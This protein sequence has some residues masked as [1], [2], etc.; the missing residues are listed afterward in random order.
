MRGMTGF[1][2]IQHPRSLDGQFT[3]R[4]HTP[5][6]L[7][8]PQ[9]TEMP[10][11]ASFTFLTEHEIRDALPSLRE[12]DG[13]PEA[14]TM[15]TETMFRTD[16]VE[17][18]LTAHP[19]LD[20][21][22]EVPEVTVSEY[23]VVDAEGVTHTFPLTTA[24]ISVIVGAAQDLHTRPADILAR[25]AH[26]MGVIGPSLMTD[27]TLTSDDLHH[28]PYVSPYQVALDPEYMSLT[29][30]DFIDANYREGL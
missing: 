29:L 15:G 23:E 8:L 30:Q 26:N 18:W 27:G 28:Y 11:G 10:L 22:F 17:Q 5:P 21:E 3:S 24:Q 7:P 2:P 16:H 14:T 19:E 4:F 12:A 1:D 9:R 6:E 13:L 25:L 20:A